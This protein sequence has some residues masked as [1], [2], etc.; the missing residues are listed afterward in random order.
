[1]GYAITRKKLLC[2]DAGHFHPTES[3][4]DKLSAVLLHLDQVLLHASRGI[5]WDSD[6]VVTLT[7]DLLALAQEVVFGQFL[8][9]VRMGLDFFDASINRIAAWVIGSR[10]MFKALLLALLQPL[11]SLRDAELNHD[12]TKRLAWLE[13]QKTLPFGAVWDMFCLRQDVPVGSAWLN[14]VKQYEK[15]VLSRRDT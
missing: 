10:A 7:D 2:L 9:R 8:S 12:Y 1:L 5:R 3:L 13:E 15:D 14:D 6:H 11:T 4:A